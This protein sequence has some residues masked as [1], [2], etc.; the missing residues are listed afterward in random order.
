MNK[1][2][3][4]DA[5][6]SLYDAIPDVFGEYDTDAHLAKAAREERAASPVE[7]PAGATSGLR[8]LIYRFGALLS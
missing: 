1:P 8:G 2:R 3:N 7:S 5:F 4:V 6:Q